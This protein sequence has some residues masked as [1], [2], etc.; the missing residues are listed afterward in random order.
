MQ[1]LVSIYF[2]EKSWG[3]ISKPFLDTLD[4]KAS[5]KYIFLTLVKLLSYFP[6]Q[7]PTR[8]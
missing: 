7:L 3:N 1:S 5:A 2:P 8:M 4:E 6:L